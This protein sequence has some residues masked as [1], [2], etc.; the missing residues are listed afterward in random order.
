MVTTKSQAQRIEA[1][2][3]GRLQRGCTTCSLRELCMVGGLGF[4]EI[5]RVEQIVHHRTPLATGETLFRCG[6]AFHSLYIVRS[7]CLRT[8]WRSGSGEEQVIG[9]HLPGEL[10]GLDAISPGCH[11]CDAVALDRASLCAIAFDELEHVAERVPALQRQLLRVVSRDWGQEHN[12]IAALGRRSARER[13][14]VFLS[15]L[16]SRIERAGGSGE[17]FQLTMSRADIANYLGLALETVSRVMTRMAD[18]GII[19]IDRKQIRILN[20]DALFTAGGNSAD[21]QGSAFPE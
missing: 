17:S 1:V 11:Q 20:R 21:S 14:A 19:S 6:D 8:T 5:N 3:L 18:E 15:S 7:G 4:P 9:F 13:L 2:D 12:H 10:V 16:A